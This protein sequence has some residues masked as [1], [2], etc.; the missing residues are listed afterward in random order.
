MKDK[1][2]Q[3]KLSKYN[4]VDLG[5]AYT[6][7]S[8]LASPDKNL[9]MGLGQ[10]GFD[11]SSLKKTHPDFIK[12]SV[13]RGQ[14][15]LAGHTKGKEAWTS[16]AAKHYG[17][18]HN[19]DFMF[20]QLGGYGEG[21]DTSKIAEY[22]LKE[23]VAAT[24]RVR[25][26][27]I[28]YLY[29][30][31]TGDQAASVLDQVKKNKSAEL[32]INSLSSWTPDIKTAAGF[33]SKDSNASLTSYGANK[34][35]IL[36][37]KVDQAEI[38]GDHRSIGFDELVVGSKSPKIK[39]LA[40]D[41][42]PVAEGDIKAPL[43]MGVAPI[44]KTYSP[45]IKKAMAAW[46]ADGKANPFITQKRA[47]EYGIL[48]AG[49]TVA[50]VGL[51]ELAKHHLDKAQE[52]YR[53]KHLAPN[54]EA[55]IKSLPEGGEAEKS[56]H[57]HSDFGSPWQGLRRDKSDKD[58]PIFDNNF[59]PGRAFDLADAGTEGFKGFRGGNGG[60]GWSSGLFGGLDV[61]ISA[62]MA[63]PKEAL[64][65]TTGAIAATATGVG[66]YFAGKAIGRFVGGVAGSFLGGPW[67]AIAGASVGGFVGGT[68]LPYMIDPYV[69]KISK[70][71]NR[72][73]GSA[74]HRLNFG[75]DYQD[76]A[77]AYSMRQ[78]A[79]QEMQGSLLNATQ[80]MGREGQLLHS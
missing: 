69:R 27:G 54:R 39:L 21:A 1:K 71:I 70:P 37:M 60:L 12:R 75:N 43:K 22:A 26:S 17:R 7:G 14:W 9:M 38:W 63:K 73:V 4:L 30:G 16:I 62:G 34:G 33:A 25:K 18:S 64:G 51:H 79:L 67:G 59:T 48:A 32:D 74:E 55:Q 2:P 61:A 68:G 5:K 42:L 78:K 19:N 76:S 23:R 29:R 72:L 80:W 57:K 41:I 28:K 58:D 45:S 11:Y 36:R 3:D 47:L 52:I 35:A 10:V 15:L 53:K 20:G 50:Y 24:N 49:V 8:I 31:I 56:R 65:K 44:F 6:V 77:P 13:L 66:G 46:S 40:E